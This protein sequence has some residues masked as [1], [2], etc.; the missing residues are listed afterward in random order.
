MHFIWFYGGCFKL[1]IPSKSQLQ[2]V[3]IPTGVRGLIGKRSTP[4][5]WNT[6]YTWVVQWW[7]YQ[8]AHFNHRNFNICTSEKCTKRTT[9]ALGTFFCGT[10]VASTR[11]NCVVL[12]SLYSKTKQSRSVLVKLLVLNK[13][14]N[15]LGL[16]QKC[17]TYILVVEQANQFCPFLYEANIWRWLFLVQYQPDPFRL[18][19]VR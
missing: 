8:L 2:N 12:K 13:C 6:Y 9:T 7:I 11:L 16:N 3:D 18:I 5:C 10:D 15:G 1:P 14:R 4:V 17:I 19:H